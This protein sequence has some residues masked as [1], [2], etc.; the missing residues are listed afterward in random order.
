MFEKRFIFQTMS[1]ARKILIQA[2][3]TGNT[4]N[5]SLIFSKS[6]LDFS[7]KSMSILIGSMKMRNKTEAKKS[8]STRWL[9]CFLGSRQMKNDLREFKS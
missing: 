7:P 6:I 4:L 5:K 3:L 2:I 8:N 1:D 9:T